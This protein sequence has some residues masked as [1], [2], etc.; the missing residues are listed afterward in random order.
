[1]HRRPAR[2]DP[3]SDR[4]THALIRKVL[5]PQESPVGKKAGAVGDKSYDA[6]DNDA[7]PPPIDELLPPLTSRNDVDLQLYAFLAIVMRDF[8]QSWYSK[9]T[10]DESFVSEILQIVAHCTRALEQRIRHVDLENLVLNEIPEIF[11]RHITIYRATHAQH[12]T[13]QVDAREAYHALWPLPLL[14]PV[15]TADSNQYD[16]DGGGASM[17]TTQQQQLQ[18]EEA[19]RQLLV[20][21]VLSILLPTEDLENPCL[22]ALVGQIFSELIIGNV[23]AKKAAQPWLLYEAICIA[24]RIVGQRREEAQT[25]KISLR[26]AGPSLGQQQQQ[27]QQEQHR[28]PKAWSVQGFFLSIIQFVLLFI[29]TV[30]GAFVLITMSSSLPSRIAETDKEG[31]PSS[32]DV[33]STPSPASSASKSPVLAFKA[34]TCLSSVIEFQTR[35]PWLSGLLSLL[36]FG[37]TRRPGRLAGL[38]GVLDR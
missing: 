24:S 5:L 34:W 29:S 21:A 2:P 30:R 10:P 14:S 20:Q 36:Q 18:N 11:D 6:H 23:I 26:R 31:V 13:Y 37:M 12:E 4:A 17:T 8:V 19:Y 15:P 22:T 32:T 16:D 9:I 25:R 7:P 35:M 33:H 1:M 28:Q 27:Q 38:D 3:L